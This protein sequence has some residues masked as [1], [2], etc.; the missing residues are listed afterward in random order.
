MAYFL[1]NSKNSSHNRSETKLNIYFNQ[2]NLPMIKYKEFIMMVCQ[3]HYSKI[4]EEKKHTLIVF[5]FCK[6]EEI[7]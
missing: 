4:A 1:E 5:I 7:E 2:I 6:Y 3:Q